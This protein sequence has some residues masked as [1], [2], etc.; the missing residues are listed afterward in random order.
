MKIR[1]TEDWPDALSVVEASIHLVR[2]HI[3][4]SMVFVIVIHY[5]LNWF[6]L[7]W[8]MVSTVIIKAQILGQS[9]T[10]ICVGIRLA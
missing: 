6:A 8:K 2:K 5:A 9:A 10:C 3:L 4:L 7:R 1:M